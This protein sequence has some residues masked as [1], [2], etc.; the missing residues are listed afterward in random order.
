MGERDTA[1]WAGARAEEREGVWGA[2]CVPVRTCVCMH[3]R[4]CVSR[5]PS[6]AVLR[7]LA[8]LGC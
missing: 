5:M 2:V 7:P 8:L 6:R 3:V 1:P 4:M